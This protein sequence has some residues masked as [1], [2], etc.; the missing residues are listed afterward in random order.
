ML[1]VLRIW[2]CDMKKTVFQRRE[3][4]S[5]FGL[6]CVITEMADLFWSADSLPLACPDPFCGLGSASNASG[7]SREATRFQMCCPCESTSSRL[8]ISGPW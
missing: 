4:S 7:R 8:S 3:A 6:I 1:G 2:L 5:C